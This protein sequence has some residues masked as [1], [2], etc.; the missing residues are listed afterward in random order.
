MVS[1]TAPGRRI[2]IRIQEPEH[3]T[4][5]LVVAVAVSGLT[6]QA[7]EALDAAAF[8]DLLNRNTAFLGIRLGGD[9]NRQPEWV[10]LSDVLSVE[11]LDTV[12]PAVA[13]G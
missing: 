12:R 11:T 4:A 8:T 5:F 13:V 6:D 9:R 3:Q 10:H 7:T 1:L 2:K